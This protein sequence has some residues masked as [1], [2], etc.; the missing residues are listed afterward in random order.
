MS[1]ILTVYHVVKLD[2]ELWRRGD[3]GILRPKLLGQSAPPPRK[4]ADADANIHSILLGPDPPR[5]HTAAVTSNSTQGKAGEGR[6]KARGQQ[7][8]QAER[9]G[10]RSAGSRVRRSKRSRD[11]CRRVVGECVVAMGAKRQS[12][13]DRVSL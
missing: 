7:V 13:K 5:S 11:S 4:R 10:Y 6:R 2:A 9:G 1:A 8:N 12:V 3:S